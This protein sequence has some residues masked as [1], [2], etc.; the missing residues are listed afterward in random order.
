MAKRASS[1]LALVALFLLV[2]C[3]SFDEAPLPGGS[4]HLSTP[5]EGPLIDE[6]LTAEVETARGGRH[7][8]IHVS[9]DAACCRILILEPDSMLTLLDATQRLDRITCTGP[10][11]RSLKGWESLPF[12]LLQI[13]RWP[14]AST[15]NGLAHGLRLTRA[16]GKT[17]VTKG[18]ALTLRIDAEADGIVLEIPDQNIRAKMSRESR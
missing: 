1:L 8:L 12:A 18:D 10:L 2:G 17:L 7:M 5:A 11:A 14:E 15:R 3:R 4:Y 9:N 13:A 16:N 6:W